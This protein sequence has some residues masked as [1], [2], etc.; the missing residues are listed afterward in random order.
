MPVSET[1][2]TANRARAL[3]QSLKLTLTQTHSHTHTLCVVSKMASHPVCRE[4]IVQDRSIPKNL[5]NLLSTDNPVFVQRTSLC[6]AEVLTSVEE[7]CLPPKV[8]HVLPLFA[9]M[10]K[11]DEAD[12]RAAVL[13]CVVNVSRRGDRHTLIAIRESGC[14]VPLFMLLEE[15]EAAYDQQL[16]RVLLILCRLATERRNKHTLGEVGLRVSSV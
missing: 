15:G 1:I 8:L 13:E 7:F 14:L 10:I 11:T 5:V 3:T 16:E 12:L 4:S 2:Y 9:S 6:L